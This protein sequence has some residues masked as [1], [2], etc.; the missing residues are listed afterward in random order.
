MK[1][2]K[3]KD[4]LNALI[5]LSF[6]IMNGVLRFKSGG[7]T[8][9]LLPTLLNCLFA[10]AAI[11][12]SYRYR[13]FKD[14]WFLSK[15][16]QH[17]IKAISDL[18]YENSL[19]AKRKMDIEQKLWEKSGSKAIELREELLDKSEVLS[20]EIEKAQNYMGKLIEWKESQLTSG[21]QQ[22]RSAFKRGEIDR[23]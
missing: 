20:S 14:Y 9:F 23:I 10:V 22:L 18:E 12:L 5:I 16:K 4:K 8:P 2:F 6:L 1:N 11:A 3:M 17:Q 15:Q 13:L 7:D 19:Y 21:I